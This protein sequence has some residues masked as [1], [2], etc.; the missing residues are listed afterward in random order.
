ILVCPTCGKKYR[1]NPAKPDG[2]YQCP[3][4]QAVLIKLDPSQAPVPPPSQPSTPTPP[5]TD[6]AQQTTFETQREF[7]ATENIAPPSEDAPTYSGGRDPLLSSGAHEDLAPED[8]ARKAAD[9]MH[10]AAGKVSTPSEEQTMFAGSDETIRQSEETV[11]EPA[12]SPT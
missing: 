3:D 7:P 4:D 11:S 1:G 12:P 9:A 2:R 5:P 8:F 6:A 10:S